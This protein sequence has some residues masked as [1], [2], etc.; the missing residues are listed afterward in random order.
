[1]NLSEYQK[2]TPTT[3]I[4]RPED[5]GY[6]LAFG[7]MGEAG[8]L[9]GKIAKAIRDRT[10]LDQ[11]AVLLECGDILYMVSQIANLKGIPIPWM[12]K[13]RQSTASGICD[14]S[15]LIC[16]AS[17]KAAEVLLHQRNDD[18]NV[19]INTYIFMVMHSLHGIAALYGKSIE[20][21]AGMN[22]EKLKSRAERG[23][24]GGSGNH[25]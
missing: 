13:D 9:C 20:D 1:M 23:V 24:L 3:A 22:Y 16:R 4:Y 6:Y 12:D 18:D 15:H 7:I 10:N 25:R 21:V 8:E 11:N 17:C 19:K 2:F 14:F 5:A